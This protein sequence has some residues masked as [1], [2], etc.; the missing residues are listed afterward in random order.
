MM[1]MSENDKLRS[2]MLELDTDILPVKGGCVWC[3]KDSLGKIK[4][5]GVQFAPN[6]ITVYGDQLFADGNAA[7]A[8]AQVN[9][10]GVGETAGGKTTASNALE[11]QVDPRVVLD[12]RTRSLYPDAEDNNVV[13][14]C[15]FAAGICTSVAGLIEAGLFNH[16]S[17]VDPA[18][19]YFMVA[20]QEGFTI[21]KAPGDSLVGTWTVTFGAS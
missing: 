18:S 4:P 8:V 6:T 17:G 2:L 19:G 21:T 3:L 15:T 13:H 9:Y 16:L 1:K 12:S 5:G 14:V 7:R 11:A 10:M 20:Y